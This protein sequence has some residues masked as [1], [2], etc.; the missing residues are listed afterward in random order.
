MRLLPKRL[1][2]STLSNKTQSSPTRRKEELSLWKLSQG[3]MP[4]SS[5][6]HT[7]YIPNFL[8]TSNISALTDTLL[9][10]K[11]DSI[12][13]VSVLLL[14]FIEILYL[15]TQNTQLPISN[16]SFFN[17]LFAISAL[18]SSWYYLCPNILTTFH[19]CS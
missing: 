5:R 2:I 14:E 1:L 18:T 3:K 8:P 7:R 15:F 4:V 6:K 10:S 19:N 13:S 12:T 9:W 11:I 16:N 17:F